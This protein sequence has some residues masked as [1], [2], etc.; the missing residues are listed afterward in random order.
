MPEVNGIDLNE[1]GMMTEEIAYPATVPG[2]TAHIDG[3]FIAYECTYNNDWL[4]EQMV[5]KMNN[6]IEFLR[7]ITGSERV[8]IHLTAGGSTKGGRYEQAR[9]K[10]YQATRKSEKPLQLERMRKFMR[11]A[12][13]AMYWETQEAD[14][15]MAQANFMAIQNGMGHLSVIVSRD[16]DLLMCPG[17]H[18][19]WSTNEVVWHDDLGHVELKQMKSSKKVVGSGGLF[20]FA[21]MLM[22]DT[23]DNIGGLP[24]VY[25]AGTNTKGGQKCGPVM[26][27]EL[28][29]EVKTLKEALVLVAGLYR[30]YG[31]HAGFAY[32]KDGQP[33]HWKD[34]FYSEA[35][36]LWM[37]RH[38]N[39]P[40]DVL[41]WFKEL[42]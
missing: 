16:K 37:R 27:Y 4:W 15:G 12:Y 38:Q 8:R 29:K 42:V 32:W 30:A 6:K 21:Q 18:L 17:L 34:A 28:L 14:D 1:L 11:D 31:E 10:E 35:R 36:L 24:R 5:E 22:G 39:R 7:K 40:D 19:N 23:A 41:N 3:D 20:F 25:G 26:A 13:K 2:R 33:V 9:L